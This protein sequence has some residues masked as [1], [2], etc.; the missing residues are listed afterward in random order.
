M[1]GLAK[2]E[3]PH[4]TQL[5]L[6][7]RGQAVYVYLALYQ[8][9]EELLQRDL[10]RRLW[11]PTEALSLAPL[12]ALLKRLLVLTARD[13][14]PLPARKPA[15]RPARRPARPRP[16]KPHKLK[17][18]YDQMVVVR[19]YYARLL[20]TLTDEDQQLVLAGALARFHQPSLNI[21]G[22]IAL[23]PATGPGCQTR[24]L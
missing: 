10:D 23:P 18:K 3:L 17:V 6:L 13:E 20:A 5:V 16:P 8:V 11:T 24:L 9:R 21:E 15:K 7:D 14:K 22:R 2:M 4:L 1:L 12:T 19:F